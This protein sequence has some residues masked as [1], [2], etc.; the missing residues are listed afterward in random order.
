MRTQLAAEGFA[1]EKIESDISKLKPMAGQRNLKV[2]SLMGKPGGENQKLVDPYDGS[3]DLEQRARAFLH[4][5]CAYCHIEAGGGNAKMNLSYY[6]ELAQMNIVNVEPT[7]HHFD[8]PDAK[9]IAPGSADRSVLLHRVSIRGPG[10][11]PQLSTNRVDQ[12]A[13]DMLRA[14]VEAMRH[15]GKN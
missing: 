5:N 11:M 13:V 9:L 6:A 3:A 4:S 15:D 14:W 1:K 2:N 10:Q 7:H 8:K 12:Q